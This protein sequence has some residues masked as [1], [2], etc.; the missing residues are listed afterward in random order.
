MFT[1]SKHATTIRFIWTSV[2]SFRCSVPELSYWEARNDA[3]SSC[4]QCTSPL[5]LLGQ[6]QNATSQLHASTASLLTSFTTAFPLTLSD[7]SF[8]DHLSSP[9]IWC[10]VHSKLTHSS[11]LQNIFCEVHRQ[12]MVLQH[13]FNPIFYAHCGRRYS[14]VVQRWVR[15]RPV[16]RWVSDCND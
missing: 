6:R 2:I 13:I 3:R 10:C 16:Q 12:E 14:E 15:F 4:R 8:C 11:F 7:R 5:K 9:K 1:G